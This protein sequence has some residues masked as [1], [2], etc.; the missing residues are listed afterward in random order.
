LGLPIDANQNAARE[1][2]NVFRSFIVDENGVEG[3]GFAVEAEMQ[4]AAGL[5]AG[6]GRKYERAESET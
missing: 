1:I 5:G 6:R 3:F 4:F 2:P